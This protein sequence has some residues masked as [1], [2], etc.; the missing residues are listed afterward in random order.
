MVQ[1]E[2]IR[3]L[4]RGYA[5]FEKYAKKQGKTPEQALAEWQADVRA[6]GLPSGY[7]AE[8]RIAAVNAEGIA[9]RREWLEGADPKEA[10]QTQQSFVRLVAPLYLPEA[11]GETNAPPPAPEADDLWDLVAITLLHSEQH[12]ED[13]GPGDG[14]R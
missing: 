14:G 11:R 12:A 13:P 5:P 3:A 10:A 6:N 1:T 8:L 4:Y 2:G 9:K 7:V